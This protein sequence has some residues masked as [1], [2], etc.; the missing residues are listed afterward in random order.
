VAAFLASLSLVAWRQGR[1][2]DSLQRLETIQRDLTLA[3]AEQEELNNRIRL[4]ESRSRVVSEAED[5]LD[6]H[7]A[8]DGEWVDLPGEG[9]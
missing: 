5:R 6:M 2:L 7:V 3:G 8:L 9:S 4:L 1:A